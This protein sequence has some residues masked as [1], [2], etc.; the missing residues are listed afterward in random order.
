MALALEA[1]KGLDGVMFGRAAY[2][3]PWI[4]TQ[5]DSAVYG[6]AEFTLTREDVVQDLIKYAVAEQDGDRSTKAL[7]RI[8]WG[9]IWGRLARGYGGEP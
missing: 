6:D 3:N 1:A 5:V 4:L 7:I 9:C 8:L 2:H